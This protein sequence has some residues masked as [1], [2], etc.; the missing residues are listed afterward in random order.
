MA[1]Q[2]SK[3][4][5][6][7]YPL[8][9]RIA[10]MIAVKL[11]AEPGATILDPCAGAGDAVAR[12]A[13]G[14][15]IPAANIAAVELDEQR[16]IQLSQ[17]L[18]DSLVFG[19]MDFLGAWHSGSASLAYINP[20]FD[21]ELGGGGR[22]EWKFID[23]AIGLL[24]T[25]GVAAIVIP[26]SVAVR[27]STKDILTSRLDSIACFRFPD[28][29]RHF[30]EVVIFGVKRKQERSAL[31]V[32]FESF[33]RTWGE[34]STYSVP[35][36]I[37]TIGLRKVEYTRSELE[38]LLRDS[39]AGA[40]LRPPRVEAEQ[41]RPPMALRQGHIA[42]LLASGCMNGLVAKPGHPPHAVRGSSKKVLR[43]TEIKEG[44][45]IKTTET[46]RIILT[47]RAITADGEI[48]SV[49]DG[50]KDGEEV[51]Q[52]DEMGGDELARPEVKN[53]S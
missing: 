53:V 37:S 29:D 33:I 36:A 19:N 20:P 11:A 2:E 16:S 4:K 22:L 34:I 5:K 51:I 45:E 14:C 25:G 30:G 3:A 38:S 18:P 32:N 15:R 1:R 47:V 27:T 52:E 44:S 43:T 39:P 9:S 6:G 12:I 21:D 10:S 13:A 50:I 23:R 35:K 41:L 24:Q 49:S 26:E 42:M 28:S 8:P 48:R 40:L 46:E 17:R 31:Y 7:Y